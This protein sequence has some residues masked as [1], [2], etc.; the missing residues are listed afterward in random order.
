MQTDSTPS[1]PVGLIHR[2]L[3]VACWGGIWGF[4]GGKSQ[5]KFCGYN[6]AT[7]SP[8]SFQGWGL[9]SHSARPPASPALWNGSL[10]GNSTK[11]SGRRSPRFH[12]VHGRTVSTHL[13]WSSSLLGQFLQTVWHKCQSADFILMLCLLKSPPRILDSSQ[14]SFGSHCWRMLTHSA[15]RNM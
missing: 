4:A 2:P 7:E 15:S 11:T 1:I 14:K 10:Q 9:F 5:L 13:M 3:N 8:H 6:F 12:Y